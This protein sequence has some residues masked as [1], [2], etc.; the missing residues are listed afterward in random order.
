MLS[1]FLKIFILWQA[2]VRHF[3]HFTHLAKA[4]PAVLRPVQWKVT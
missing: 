3:A 2:M 4:M 1:S